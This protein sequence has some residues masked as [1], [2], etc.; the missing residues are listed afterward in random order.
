[1]S[2]TIAVKNSEGND[3][4]IVAEIK[5]IHH[6]PLSGKKVDLPGTV[7]FYLSTGQVLNHI[8]EERFEN[9]MTEESYYVVN[10]K[11]TEWLL[12]LKPI[13]AGKNG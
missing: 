1:M 4:Y 12:S 7:S 13:D 11:D 8:S 9:P 5:P 6:R 10:D 2:R 3:D